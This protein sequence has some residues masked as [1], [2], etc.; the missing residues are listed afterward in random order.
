MAF[1]KAAPSQD[2]AVA[3]LRPLRA[4]TEVQYSSKASRVGDGGGGWPEKGHTGRAGRLEGLSKANN[5]SGREPGWG[6]LVHTNE[7]G[8]VGTGRRMG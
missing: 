3:F 4:N 8:E 5:H 6:T 1:L 7:G 2:R